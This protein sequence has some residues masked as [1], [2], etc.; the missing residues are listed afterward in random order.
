MATSSFNPMQSGQSRVFILEGRARADHKPTYMSTVKAGSPSQSYGDVEKIEIPHPT[1]YDKFLEVG[2]IRGAEENVSITLTGRYARDIKSELL[3]MAK[4]LCPVDVQINFGACKDPTAYNRFD[5]KII[6]EDAVLTNWGAEDLGA[7]GSDERAKVDENVDVSAREIYEIVELT[8]GEKAGSVVTNE[9]VDMV[10][11]DSASCGDCDEESSG[12]DK[13]FA[14]SLAAGGSGGTPADVV[15]SLDKGVSWDAHDIDS[16]G[17]AE[18]PDGVACLGS[19]LFVVSEDSES[20]HYALKSEFD[21]LTDPAFTAVATG[22]V[23]GGGPK[24][25]DVGIAKAFIVGAGG[26]IYSTED[27][28]AGVTVLDAGTIHDVDYNDVSALSDEFAVAVGDNGNIAKTTDGTLWTGVTTTPI[29]AGVSF[30]AI[31]VLSENTWLLGTG[32]GV[33]YY[34]VNGGTSFTTKAFPGS[35]AGV[36]RD[37]VSAKESVLFMAHDTATPA[38]RVLRSIN[39]GYDWYVLPEGSGVIPANDQINALAACPSNPDLFAGGGLA[40]DASDGFVVVGTA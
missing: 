10:I 2:K 11:C 5:K 35:G 14:I 6:L 24:A 17:V 36:I 12:C 40:D 15:F 20:L 38:G 7:L 4:A 25:V 37:I 13:F 1:Q 18:N 3:R 28:T 39:G 30:N 27:P 32:G 23:A 31:L 33:L 16:L 29:G 9:I 21:G 26:Y 22:F 19:Y 8:L 34:T